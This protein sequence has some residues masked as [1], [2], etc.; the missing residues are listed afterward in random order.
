MAS[1]SNSPISASRNTDE[2]DVQEL[3]RLM[4]RNW[5]VLL[6]SM[7]VSGALAFGLSFAFK[8]VYRADALL[9]ASDE[10]RGSSSLGSIAGEFGGLAAIAG[11][12]GS[13]NGQLNEAIATLKSRILT[14]RYIDQ[15]D[16]LPILFP[17][18][19]DAATKQ[20]KVPPSKIPTD[21]DG[22]RLFDK[23]IRTVSEDKKTG[24]ITISVDWTDPQLA[25]KWVRD[26]VN[27]TNEYL[28]AE[29]LE[30]SNR[31]L[32][33]L[34]EQ[35]NK[36]SVVEL[37][38]AISKLIESQIKKAMAAQGNMEYAFHFIDP[39]VVPER[40]IAP[41][42]ITFFLGGA[43]IGLFFMTLFLYSRP[44]QSKRVD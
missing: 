29:A 28:R 35:L 24:L 10:I 41:K 5:L 42:R 12:G 8:P 14:E 17:D 23:K 4:G 20:W 32:D 31:N 7:L 37:R 1:D 38:T 11:I 33:Y 16:L 15:S 13:R 43:L 36:A 19:W 6:L 34:K 22:Y 44:S 2:L 9:T 21:Q 3:L 26:L 40:K 25:A 30:R 18:R 27:L 39:P